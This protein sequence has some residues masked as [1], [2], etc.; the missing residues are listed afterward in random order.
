MAMIKFNWLTFLTQF[1]YI[2]QIPIVVDND[3]LSSYVLSINWHQLYAH[4]SKIFDSNNRVHQ[5][6]L[7]SGC[8]LRYVCESWSVYMRIKVCL[9]ALHSD[10]WTLDGQIA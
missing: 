7:R 2:H 3:N 9:Y 4:L 5:Y 10:D 6:H 1:L 8:E